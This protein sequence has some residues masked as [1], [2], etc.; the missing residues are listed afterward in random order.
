M[1]RMINPILRSCGR[2]W[3]GYSGTFP[4]YMA[5][6]CLLFTASSV[7]A[8]V[9][10]VRVEQR[11]GSQVVD[12]YYDLSGEADSYTVTL[13]V[14][15]D[16]GETYDG[17]AVSLSGDIG[18][19]VHPGSNR[20]IAWDA[21]SDW[22]AQEYTRVRV[23]ITAEPS[24]VGPAPEGFALIPAGSFS[25]G[26]HFGDGWSE[27]LPVH[28]VYVSAF[29]M[30]RTP[31][32]KAQWDEVRS[33]A[34]SNGYTDLPA[35]GGKG[36]DH[37][38]H[39]VNWFDAVKWL[40]AWSERD[41]LE[42]VY[43]VGGTVYKTGEN[44]PTIDY[45][46]NGYR[47]PTEAEWEK[48]GRG[49]LSGRRFPWGDTISHDEANYYSSSSYSYDV[50]ATRG[51]HPAYND[52]TSPYTSPVGSFAPNGY[53]LYDMAGN[54][55][56]WCNDW[57]SGTYYSTSPAVDPTGPSSGS[58]RVRRGGGWDGNAVSTRVSLRRFNS[59]AVRWNNYGFRPARS[60]VP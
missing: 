30:G 28:T 20:H 46:A 27:E 6:A 1:I 41:G 50:S 55:W 10:N 16:G 43:R 47:L 4:L 15:S 7:A 5:L 56:E 11:S 44:T 23:R 59:P 33:W 37:P 35:G 29:Y 45:S 57:Y 26:D 3:L 12:V 42:P 39:S 51:H 34:A 58:Y 21:G 13:E 17:S 49:G 60:S 48:A 24:D 38:V 14:S 2:K 25:M 53:G 22:E 8:G 18:P 32:T 36:P 40:N 54:V 52:G 31:L 9:S 19:G